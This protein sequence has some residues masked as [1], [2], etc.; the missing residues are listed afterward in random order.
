MSSRLP[1]STTNVCT[2]APSFLHSAAVSSTP[3]C[4]WKD[5]MQKDVGQLGDKSREKELEKKFLER[6]EFM[7][8]MP[9]FFLKKDLIYS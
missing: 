4:D 6:L 8:K 1:Q 7:S 9:S 3:C 2:V 5:Q